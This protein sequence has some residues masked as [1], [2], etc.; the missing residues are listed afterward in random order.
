MFFRM[1]IDPHSSGEKLTKP[2][3]GAS[4][5]ISTGE[6]SVSVPRGKRV[7]VFTNRAG[8]EQTYRAVLLAGKGWQ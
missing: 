4:L 3:C 1:G 7:F 5:G 2:E 6:F 8:T